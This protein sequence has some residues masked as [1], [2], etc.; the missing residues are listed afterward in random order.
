ML[1]F[2][3]VQAGTLPAREPES[4]AGRRAPEGLAQRDQKGFP[5][6]MGSEVE[7][8]SLSLS[9]RTTSCSLNDCPWDYSLEVELRPAVEDFTGNPTH[10]S[11]LISRTNRDC[12]AFE[13]GP[14]NV[15]GLMHG[16]AY[17]WQAREKVVAYEVF[18]QEGGLA[19]KKP[20]TYYSEWEIHGHSHSPSFVISALLIRKTKNPISVV[21]LV[22]SGANGTAN[23]LNLDDDRYYRVWATAQAPYM[24]SWYALFNGIDRR[25]RDLKIAYAG[26]NSQSCFQSLHIW[27]WDL[28]VWIELDSR[29]AGEEEIGIDD[30]VPPGDLSSYVSSSG[31]G[32]VKV[33]VSCS[34]DLLSFS[35]NGNILKLS[36]DKPI[37]RP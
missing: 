6:K 9:A 14:L 37:S 28:E 10:N 15:A 19:C 23:R 7:T 35:S 3:L 27:D 17:K 32:E 22:G 25:G 5:V 16:V 26:N 24:T 21:K 8:A 11:P 31:R 20:K 13:Y 1:A 12:G 2:Y 36:Y 29:E 30:L 4:M 18:Y 33:R 34:S